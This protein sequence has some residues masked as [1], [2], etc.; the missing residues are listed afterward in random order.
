MHGVN[1]EF[2][3]KTMALVAEN[4]SSIDCVCSSKTKKQI[5]HYFIIAYVYDL[6]CL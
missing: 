3:F 5:P 4:S 1:A 2:Q 6:M